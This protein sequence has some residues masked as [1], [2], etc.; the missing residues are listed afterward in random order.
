[1]IIDNGSMPGVAVGASSI[2]MENC[3]Y[4]VGLGSLIM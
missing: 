1:V 3:E 2:E 4:E